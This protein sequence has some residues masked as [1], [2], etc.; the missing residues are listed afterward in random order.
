MNKIE[1]QEILFDAATIEKRVKELAAE[2]SRDYAGRE[3]VL[4]GVLKG[5]VV[6]LADLIRGITIPLSLDFVHASSYGNS[7][8][9]SRQVTISR[10]ADIDVAGRHVLLVD[11]IIDTG[12]TLSRLFGHFQGKGPAS[13][14]AVVLLDKKPCRIVDVP[15]AYRGFEIQ[16]VFVVGYGADC[17]QHCRNLPYVA[18]IKPA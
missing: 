15:L 8:T 3:P 11:G 7:T 9:S 17:A 1:I 13:L 4:V 2:I 5:A 18:V 16:D 12:L 14:K 6:F 10:D